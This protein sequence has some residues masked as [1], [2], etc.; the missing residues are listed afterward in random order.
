MAFRSNNA[1]SFGARRH[2][3]ASVL[4][5]LLAGSVLAGCQYLPIGFTPIGDIVSRPA[6]F[7]GRQIKIRGQV[8]DVSKIPIIDFRTYVLKDDSG[9]ITVVAA[10]DLPAV[11]ERVAVRGH[12]ESAAILAGQSFGLMFREEKKLPSW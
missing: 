12:A 3:A 10:S 8:V 2:V 6:E 1:D 7:E 4:R 5:I 11:G 9:S